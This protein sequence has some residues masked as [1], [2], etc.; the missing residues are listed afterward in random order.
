[1]QFVTIASL[2]TFITLAKNQ[3]DGNRFVVRKV[4][5]KR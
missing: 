1:M 4:S 2:I 3:P 5:T